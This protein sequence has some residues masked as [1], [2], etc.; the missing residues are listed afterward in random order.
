MSQT[1]TVIHSQRKEKIQVICPTCKNKTEQEIEL[2]SYFTDK[3]VK[4]ESKW[5]VNFALEP[6]LT[7]LSVDI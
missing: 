1:E 2:S 3:C 7:I 6:V 5:V 4:C